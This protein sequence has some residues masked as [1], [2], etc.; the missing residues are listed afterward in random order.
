MSGSLAQ[1]KLGA[2]G[3]AQEAQRGGHAVGLI[4]FD[5][6]AAHIASPQRTMAELGTSIDSLVIGGS[7]NLTAAISLAVH[8]LPARGSERVIYIVTDGMPDD[9]ASALEAA[10]M[11]K[12]Q[13]IKIMTLGTDGADKNYLAKIASSAALAVKVE[14]AA[15]QQGISSM[16]RLLL[17]DK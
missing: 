10:S 13:G 16:A 8:H 7:T 14:R 5:S 17:A 1:A 12:R 9:P 2:S 6:D 11:A 15:L 4:R 3:F